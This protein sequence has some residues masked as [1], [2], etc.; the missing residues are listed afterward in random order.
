MCVCV[1]VCV[2]VCERERGQG[3]ITVESAVLIVAC[4]QIHTSIMCLS[5][6]SVPLSGLN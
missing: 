4:L 5:R 2:C 3:H 6:N 1:C